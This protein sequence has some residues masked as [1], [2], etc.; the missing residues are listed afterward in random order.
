MAGLAFL[1]F[2]SVPA[3]RADVYPTKPVHIILGS[4]P[5]GVQD[6]IA[7][8]LSEQLE[9]RLHQSVIIDNR[10]GAG[11]TLGGGIAAKSAPD[12][13][14]FFIGAISNMAIAP[15]QYKSMPY[16]PET[17]FIPVTQLASSSN[18]LVAYPKSNYRTVADVIAAGK[19]GIGVPMYATAGLGTSPHM[20]GALFNSMAGTKLPNVPYRGD[21]PALADVIGGRVSLAFPALP[22]AVTFIQ[23]KMLRAIA[24]TGKSRSPMFPDVPTI[25]ES[26]IPGYEMNL[27]VGLFAPAGTPNEIVDRM[28][29]E[30][31]AILTTKAIEQKFAALGME[32]IGDSPDEFKRFLKS[33][34]DKWTRVA[35]SAGIKPE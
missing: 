27:W 25:A 21:S 10:P 30:V 26:G 6:M 16:K 1:A 32:P 23:S 34:V 17:D 13:Y 12:G 22:S 5:G 3:A 29:R 2:A 31:V 8:L 14:T 11:G 19:K 35:K 28:N 18:I 20:A 24:V 15:S 9:S 33:E 7:R 4:P